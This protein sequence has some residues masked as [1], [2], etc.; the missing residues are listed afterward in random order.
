MTDMKI[1]A[2]INLLL[3]VHL[4]SSVAHCQ[5]NFIETERTDALKLIKIEALIFNK[6]KFD[7]ALLKLDSIVKNAPDN[8]GQ[9]YAEQKR[10]WDTNEYD[11][12]IKFTNNPIPFI[13]DAYAKVYYFYAVIY[14]ERGEWE[15]AEQY[16][17]T[18]LKQI[19]DEAHLLCEMGM[20]YQQ[21]Y[22]AS[23]D[24]NHLDLSSRY[25]IDAIDKNKKS[26]LQLRIIARAL[27]GVGFNLIEAGELDLAENFFIESLNYEENDFAYHE[28]NYINQLRKNANSR[29][30]I[31]TPNTNSP[32]IERD[33]RN[34]CRQ[35]QKKCTI[36]KG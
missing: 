8:Y 16:L 35:K 34:N 9:I 31:S 29:P 28:L 13:L 22:S 32:Q 30:S 15:K 12:Y 33:E 5:N 27:R 1:Y 11:E 20:L 21:Q 25:F 18:G 7:D 3:A 19:P 24:N 23:F 26:F 6:R 36:V 14:I 2:W 4:M 17:L 10:F